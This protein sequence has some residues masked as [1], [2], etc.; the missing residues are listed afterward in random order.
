MPWNNYGWSKL[1]AES[2]VH[3]Y[4]NSLIVRACM[5]EKPFTHKFAFTNVKTNF[6]FH[7]EFANLLIKVMPLKG[8]I[9]VGGNSQT[10]FEF[11]RKSNKKIKR[12][13]SKGELPFRMDM[14]I[15]K[16]NKL[17]KK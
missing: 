3:L 4:K 10:I 11:A 15:S 1:G 7:N 12:R 5:T 8:V 17:C 2:S 16:L 14:N 9:N 6:I 13:K